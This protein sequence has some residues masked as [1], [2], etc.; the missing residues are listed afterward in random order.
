MIGIY[1]PGEDFG[2]IR[3]DL[4]DDRSYERAINHRGDGVIQGHAASYVWRMDEFSGELVGDDKVGAQRDFV[5]D[6]DEGRMLT[7]EEWSAKVRAKLGA[8]R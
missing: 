7:S 5:Y 3:V 2:G 4:E 6:H 1:Q 8:K